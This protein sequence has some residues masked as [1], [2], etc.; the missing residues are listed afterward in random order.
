MSLIMTE[1][2]EGKLTIRLPERVDTSNVNAF[3]DELETALNSNLPKAVVM[4]ATDLLYISSVGLRELLYIKK[5][6]DDFRVLNV[7]RDIYDI[8]ETTGFTKIMDVERAF[9]TMSVVGCSLIGKGACGTVYKI[10]DERI[11]KVFVKGY[12][13]EK[14]LKER[15]N[16]K[17]AFT[18]G[19]DTAIPFDIVKVGDHYGLIYEIIKAKTLKELINEEPD[20]LNFYIT[21]YAKYIKHMHE[22]VFEAGSYPDMK[23]VWKA[24]ID[25]LEGIFSEEEKKAV[26]GIIDD[27]SDRMTFVHGDINFGNMMI[28]D[29]KT[30]M[31][32][33]EDVTLGHPIY[34][35]AFLYYI[36]T[37]LP[38]MLPKDV[39]FD[40]I[41]FS[42]EEARALW[43]GFAET[44]FDIKNENDL[45]SYEKQIHPYGLIRLLDGVPSCFL[46]FEDYDE[47]K[48]Q[49]VIARYQPAAEEYKAS[50]L[51]AIKNGVGK[52][53]F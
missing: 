15:D 50:L 26:K 11:V 32:D 27:L 18:H 29:G 42:K 41:R 34:D 44:Y 25:A 3:H 37:L 24:K 43:R 39:Y 20:R 16:A 52:P 40:M 6:W 19:I 5:N 8:F 28:D 17:S 13:F 12:E 38:G 35:V 36:L 53:E 33:M 47:K 4:D 2:R 22:T 31:I 45:R 7:A 10:D 30:V 1:E 49:A 14:V 21:A 9:E 51:A 48:K 23:T 46:T